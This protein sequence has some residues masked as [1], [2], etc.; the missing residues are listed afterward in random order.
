MPMGIGGIP[1]GE[2]GSYNDMSLT[3]FI[4]FLAGLGLFLG[5]VFISTDNYLLFVDLASLL[6]VVGGTLA[7]TFMGQEA[8]YVL[9][10][11]RSMFGIMRVQR[12]G[13]GILNQ[14][15][16]RIIRWGYIVQAKG[17]LALEAEVKKVQ[18]DEFLHF[19]VELVVT[20]Y[21][22][23]D[24]RAIMNNMAATTFER[25][26]VQVGIL[27]NMANTAPAFGM[28]G[29]LVG[30]IIMLD[31]MGSDPA[32]LGP[33]LAVALCTT[34]YGVLL[35]R[36]LLMPAAQK[37][38]QRQEIM[39]FRNELMAEGLALLAERNSP[40]YIQDKMNSFLDPAI[41]FNID[42]QLKREQ[43]AA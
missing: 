43:R 19:G 4:A 1:A 36:L 37:L 6:M 8:R 13:R 23:E 42:Q 10:A 30:L 2:P 21:E 39:R 17:V 35:A 15:V 25:N 11:L 26:M 5:S 24:V 28:V 22:G 31:T 34:L 16:G 7:A 38:Q 18:G 27:K 33:A 9:L 40:R 20:G 3:T 29:T 41:R 32:S 14:E 12:I